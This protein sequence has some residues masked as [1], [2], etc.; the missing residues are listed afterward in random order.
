MFVFFFFSFFFFFFFF[1][2]LMARELVG[3]DARPRV[4]LM[5]QT[6][7]STGRDF[8]GN[9]CEFLGRAVRFGLRRLRVTKRQVMQESRQGSSRTD[10]SNSRRAALVVAL[11][12]W[13]SGIVSASLTLQIL[14]HLAT[15][16]SLIRDLQ[17]RILGSG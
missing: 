2:F 5:R 10:E 13:T 3:T 1:F 4:A 8:Y 6:S 15:R 16:R 7:G 9:I 11:C 17:C 12:G 14:D